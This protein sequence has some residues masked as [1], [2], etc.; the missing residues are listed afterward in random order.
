VLAALGVTALIRYESRRAE[1]LIDPRFFRSIPF[2]GATVIA[3]CGFAALGGFLFLNTLYLQDVRGY[4]ALAAGVA[5]VP[6]ALMSLFLAPTSGRIV[7]AR[8]PRLPLIIAG[9]GLMA[10]A[11]VLSGLTDATSLGLLIAAYALFG[12]GFGMLNAPITNTAVSGMPRAQAGVAAAIASTSRQI[13]QSL[14]VAV[15]GT[16]VPV[17][18]DGSLG[19][20]FSTS[21]HLGWWIIFGCGAVVLALGLWTTGRR[22]RATADQ[23][24]RRLTIDREHVESVA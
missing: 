20:G 12:A 5:T 9:A 7:G 18:L 2:S 19:S 3:I 13:G 24:A 4:S 15:I 21:T 10:S 22:A 8:G 16:T 6:M 11:L 23:T 14:G 17:G 1:P